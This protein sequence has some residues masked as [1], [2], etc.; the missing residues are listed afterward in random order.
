MLDAKKENRTGYTRY[1]QGLDANALN[2]T[3][4]GV[5]MIMN[6]SQKRMKLMARIMAE[7]LVAPIFKG[8]L[9]TLSDYGMEALAFRLNNKFVQ[10]DPQEWRDQFDMTINVGLGSADSQQ[11]LVML[12]QIAQAQA[13]V[14]QSPYAGLVD[15]QRVYNL[16]ARMAEVAGF[17][18]P[19]EFWVNPETAPPQPQQEPQTDPLVMAEQVKAQAQ[20]QKA[21]AEMQFEA[22]KVQ[23]EMTADQQKTIA[24][25]TLAKQ[26]F[27][28]ELAFKAEEAEKDRQHAMQI[29]LVKIQARQQEVMAPIM[30]PIEAEN[31]RN[32]AIATALATLA[33]ALNAPKQVIRDETGR[34]I[35]VAPVAH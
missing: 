13:M 20:G 23:A 33:Q 31:T 10:Y 16:Q 6:A 9:K 35:G 4:T 24:E 17:K 27:E 11:K 30:A 28:M 12:Q 5:S 1:S 34:A 3:A 8:I 2:K 29:E 15:A 14:V 25:M 18:N 21:Q 26:K 32:D 7:C 22:Q 19:Q